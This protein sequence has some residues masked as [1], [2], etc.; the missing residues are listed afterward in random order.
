MRESFGLVV[1]NLCFY[2]PEFHC[3]IQY[4]ICFIYKMKKNHFISL[5][6]KNT[7]I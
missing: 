4:R 6:S 7:P 1:R 5:Q 3:Q 2:V